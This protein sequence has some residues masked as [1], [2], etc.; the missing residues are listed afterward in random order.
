MAP[1]HTAHQWRAAA[2][3]GLCAALALATAARAGGDAGDAAEEAAR[4]AGEEALRLCLQLPAGSESFLSTLEA[5]GWQRGSEA[6]L[7]AFTV[8]EAL[9]FL[10]DPAAP[11]ETGRGAVN[12]AAMIID[13][14]SPEG[15]VVLHRDGVTLGPFGVGLD[16]PYC[17]LS[18]PAVLADVAR[19]AVAMQPQPERSSEGLVQR[20]GARRMTV[21]TLEPAAFAAAVTGH[22]PEEIRSSPS[23]GI[24]AVYVQILP[25][26]ENG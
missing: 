23:F 25:S 17:A 22:I 24:E 3:L 12:V 14:A 10:F 18:G 6:D 9:A 13:A 11:A 20:E 26:P 15:R 5:A 4:A 1:S 19:A 21:A 2:A 8:E 16:R 7:V